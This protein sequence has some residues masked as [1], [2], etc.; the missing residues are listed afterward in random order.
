[1]LRAIKDIS[2]MSKRPILPVGLR[3]TL[4]FTAKCSGL[5]SINRN[6]SISKTLI[7]G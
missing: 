2:S 4:E 7:D 5:L 6:I 1:M 3:I